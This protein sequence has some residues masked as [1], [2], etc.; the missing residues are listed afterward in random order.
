MYSD[1]KLL[2]ISGLQHIVFCPRQCALI[3]VEKL[4]IEN[5][6]TYQ[7]RQ[8]HKNVHKLGHEK[9]QDKRK[10]KAMQIVSYKYAI[11][12]EADMVE[13]DKG[14][15]VKIVEHKRGSPKNHNADKV[16]LCAQ[17]M[18]LE[19]MLNISIE[20]GFLFYNKIKRRE[21]VLLD[22][23]LRG[24]TI[25]AIDDFRSM[26]QNKYTPKGSYS[27]SCKSCSFFDICIPKIFDRESVAAYIKK[28]A[29]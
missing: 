20:Y 24:I 2:P 17:A 11:F 13:F 21:K 1:E 19:E 23:S 26:M 29:L 12:G 16:Q 18:C 22:D 15:S 3:H 6:L 7:G 28:N 5:S 10:E 8:L 4:W 14:G 9:R 27:P 25:K